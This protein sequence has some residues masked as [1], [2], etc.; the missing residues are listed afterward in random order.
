MECEEPLFIMSNTTDYLHL[1]SHK[2]RPSNWIKLCSGER[3]EENIITCNYELEGIVILND[4]Q[5]CGGQK[6]E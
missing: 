5:G 1:I 6:T 2:E 4:M 3:R